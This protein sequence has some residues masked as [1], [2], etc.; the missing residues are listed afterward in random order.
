MH[1]LRLRSPMFTSLASLT[2]I[3]AL[4]GCESTPPPAPEDT[5]G[6]VG[7]E[8]ISSKTTGRGGAAKK[9]TIKTDMEGGGGIPKVMQ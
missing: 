8:G 7:G 9:P 5:G 1:L 3:L 6:A 2:L 4:A